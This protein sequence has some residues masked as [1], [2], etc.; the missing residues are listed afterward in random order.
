MAREACAVGL[1]LAYGSGLRTALGL[2]WGWV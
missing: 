1:Y 2:G